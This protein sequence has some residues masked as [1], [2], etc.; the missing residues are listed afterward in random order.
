M[1]NE[2]KFSFEKHF[3]LKEKDIIKKLYQSTMPNKYLAEFARFLFENEEHPFIKKIIIKGMDIFVENHIL[4]YAQ[5]LKIVPL[6][7]VGSI[8]YHAQEYIE[9]ALNKKNLKATSY[10]RRP[11]DNLVN[12]IKAQ[13][14]N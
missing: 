12:H 2:L 1:P 4:L 8:A 10:I 5:E 14:L 11:I 13:N 9:I 7:F 3:N 6:H